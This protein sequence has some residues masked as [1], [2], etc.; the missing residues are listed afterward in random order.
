MPFLS[1][2]PDSVHVENFRIF[3]NFRKFKKK[4]NGKE[5]VEPVSSL[6]R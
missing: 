6:D 5:E 1:C 2:L 3:R 4:G